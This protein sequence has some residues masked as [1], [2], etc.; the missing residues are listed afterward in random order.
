MKITSVFRTCLA[1]SLPRFWCMLI[2]RPCHSVARGKLSKP[3]LGRHGAA[4]VVALCLAGCNFLSS[5]DEYLRVSSMNFSP[6]NKT[7]LMTYCPPDSDCTLGMYDFDTAR[8]SVF[9]PSTRAGMVH[10]RFSPDGQYIVLT[11]IKAENSS[12]RQ[13]ATVSTD[14]SNYQ[15][16]TSSSDHKA[17]PTVSPDGKRLL[18]VKAGRERDSGMTRF[19]RYDIYEMDIASQQEVR[20][21]N[22]EFFEIFPPMYFPDGEHIIFSGGLSS[23]GRESFRARFKD[24]TIF[25]MSKSQNTLHPAFSRGEFSYAPSISADGTKILFMSKSNDLDG[26]RGNFNY[27]LFVKT[28]E[29]IKRLTKLNSVL[30]DGYI[31][32]DGNRVVFLSDKERN[33]E[34]ALMVMNSDGTGLKKI[35]LPVPDRFITVKVD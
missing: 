3:A 20:L 33:H 14:G 24:N 32:P 4:F 7:L 16:L 13:I 30:S 29:G 22:F 31:S 8:L 6:D 12:I 9:Q 10:G 11:V 35:D 23:G 27:D 17:F 5:E 15:L 19:S 21:T 34:P 28:P 2:L 26:L 18:L 25:V 1:A